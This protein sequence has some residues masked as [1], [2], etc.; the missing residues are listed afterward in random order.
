MRKRVLPVHFPQA[1]HHHSDPHHA[2]QRK[3]L[4]IYNKNMH[5]FWV[6]ETVPQQV[7]S[8]PSFYCRRDGP[9]LSLENYFQQLASRTQE[10]ANQF[11]GYYDSGS[12][13]CGVDPGKPDR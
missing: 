10:S 3:K 1:H 2:I 4:E 11:S 9:T 5:S 12:H 8:G 6:S 7:R 13:M